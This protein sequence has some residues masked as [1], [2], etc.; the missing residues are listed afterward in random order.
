MCVV[1]VQEKTSEKM[2]S[3]R[4]RKQRASVG[5]HTRPQRDLSRT[6][7]QLGSLLLRIGWPEALQHRVVFRI[8]GL[9]F[10]IFG[11]CGSSQDGVREA[12]AV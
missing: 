10:R 4:L 5:A 12:N 3:C 1:N 9:Q 2:R 8:E 11:F 7:E 6:R